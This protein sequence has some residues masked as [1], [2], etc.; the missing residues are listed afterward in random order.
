MPEP[1]VACLRDR[2]AALYRHLREPPRKKRMY[3]CMVPI[4]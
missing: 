4:C 3:Q 2:L 1:T